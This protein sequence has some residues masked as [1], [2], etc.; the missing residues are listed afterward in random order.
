MGKKRVAPQMS[1]PVIDDE[2]SDA[3]VDAFRRGDVATLQLMGGM[4]FGSEDLA[5]GT[6]EVPEARDGAAQPNTAPKSNAAAQPARRSLTIDAS[7]VERGKEVLR[8][9][10]QAAPDAAAD[11]QVLHRLVADEFALVMAVN[12]V[13]K[14]L[15]ARFPLL[16]DNPRLMLIVAKT[17]RELVALNGAMSRRIE[18]ALATASTLRASRRMFARHGEVVR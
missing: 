14:Q 15:A 1:I 2:F 4:H 18:G 11:E 5:S 10:S 9:L 17:M 7:F 13:E 3:A 8:E 6:P 16:L 12:D